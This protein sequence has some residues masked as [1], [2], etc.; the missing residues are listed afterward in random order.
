MTALKK[1]V[2][3]R[4]G[5]EVTELGFG[6][7]PIGGEA[8]GPVSEN[9]A[10]ETIETYVSAGGNLI[11]TAPVYANSETYIGK[12]LKG[13]GIRE[14]IFIATKTMKGDTI[15]TIPDIKQEIDNS[16]RALQ[17]DYVDIYF[18]H[19]PPDEPDVMNR[20]IDEFEKLKNQGKIR[21][22]GASVKLANV[23]PETVRLCRQYIDTGRVDVLEVA[24]SILRQA[25]A[26]NFAYAHEKGVGIIVRTAIE[27]G[28]LTGR[29]KPGDVFTEGHRKRWSEQTLQ[30][31]LKHASELQTYAIRRPYRSLAQVALRFALVP[32]EVSCVIVG[33]EN[34]EEVL[35]NI[36]TL[37][38]PPLEEDLLE[39]LRREFEG[40]TQ[41]FNLN[42]PK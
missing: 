32:K 2:L 14:K 42:P 31:I 30:E 24:Y 9:N 19:K 36:E 28:F 10:I 11:D 41:L 17:T 21:A 37:S 40:K 12:A 39:R 6:A 4:T 35:K 22:I 33:A 23:T 20:A 29:Y 15:E 27:S 8:Y 1:R 25:N 38:L 18:L 26:E 5:F 16:L 34:P 13:K 3:G 7:W